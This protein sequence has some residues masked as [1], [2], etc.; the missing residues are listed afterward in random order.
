LSLA[1]SIPPLSRAVHFARRSKLAVIITAKD[2]LSLRLFTLS[3]LHLFLAS[4]ESPCSPPTPSI[5]H[6]E[7]RPDRAL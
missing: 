3:P 4:G 5:S 6:D 7:R 2:L 1:P